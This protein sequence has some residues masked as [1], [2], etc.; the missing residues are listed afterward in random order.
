[1][2][3]EELEAQVE[4]ISDLWYEMY[5]TFTYERVCGYTEDDKLVVVFRNIQKDRY[6][7]VYLK[8]NRL[9]PLFRD[10]A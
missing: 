9:R 8:D 3:K 7:H 10:D 2:T 4:R 5:S 1:M 6:I